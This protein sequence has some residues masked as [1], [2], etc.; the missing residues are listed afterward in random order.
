M[1]LQDAVFGSDLRLC[2]VTVSDKPSLIIGEPS[3]QSSIVVSQGFLRAADHLHPH[4][5][6]DEIREFM[7]SMEFRVAA[8]SYFGW[9]R[10]D[11]V[12]VVDAKP[13]NFVITES[14]VSPV[15]LQIA[16]FTPA[17]MEEI[18]PSAEPF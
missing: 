13:D 15:D 10:S 18:G 16:V 3:G 4:P 2:G 1:A 6:I 5:G 17:E 11:G 9:H 14:G 8:G 12:V 7:K